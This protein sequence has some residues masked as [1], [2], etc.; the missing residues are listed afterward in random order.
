[1]T[2]VESIQVCL[3]KYVDFN[4]IA[5]RSEFWWFVLFVFLVSLGLNFVSETIAGLWG[6]AM[7]LPELAVG[8][9]RLHDIGKS[10]WWQLLLLI[11]ILGL[12]ILIVLW[13]LPG[14]D[15]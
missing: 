14:K 11:P 10:G 8:A 5:V 7:L 12:V 13:V 2:F 6:L 1:M 4:G 3:K 9:R 15:E